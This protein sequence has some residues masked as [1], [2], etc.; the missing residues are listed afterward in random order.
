[1]RGPHMRKAYQDTR[2]NSHGCEQGPTENPIYTV[3]NVMLS[4]LY[5]SITSR[6]KDRKHGNITVGCL[7]CHLFLSA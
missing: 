2:I 7:F 4:P 5:K 6:I 3:Q 1:M